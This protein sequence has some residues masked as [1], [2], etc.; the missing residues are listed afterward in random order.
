M[1]GKTDTSGIHL[2]LVLMKAHQSLERYALRSIGQTGLGFSDF[3]VLETL[4]H[5]GPLPVNILGAGI[6]LTSGSMTAAIDR[7]Q[8]RHLVRRG[9][10]SADRRARIVHLTAEG[11]RLIGTAF[12]DHQ[13]AMEIAA[14]SVTPAERAI[15]IRLLKKLGKAALEKLDSS[16]QKGEPHVWTTGKHRSQ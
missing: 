2:W 14:E 5:K 13:A 12:H 4:L 16:P 3:A 6:P 1:P 11:R 8:R 9:V 7:L 10:D 15:L